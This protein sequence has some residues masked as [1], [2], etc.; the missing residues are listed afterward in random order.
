VS[1]PVSARAHPSR[2]EPTSP[3]PECSEFRFGRHRRWSPL[4]AAREANACGTAL[5]ARSGWE[6]ARGT[7]AGALALTPV[8]TLLVCAC[9]E[10]DR[11]VPYLDEPG[12][13]V[14][15]AHP[16]QPRPSRVEAVVDRPPRAAWAGGPRRATRAA[17]RRPRD[18]ATVWVSRVLERLDATCRSDRGRVA[19][20]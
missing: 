3:P 14:A 17:T 8:G 13:R 1:A 7:P 6:T 4:V 9:D 18:A 19:S 2:H 11:K 15:P 20:R 10:E 5:P 16:N 12:R